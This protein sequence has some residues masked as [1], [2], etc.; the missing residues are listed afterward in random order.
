LSEQR[1]CPAGLKYNLGWK[2]R[3]IEGA[4][5]SAQGFGHSSGQWNA[6]FDNICNILKR[7][8][9]WQTD[10]GASLSLLY[11]ARADR[12]YWIYV[13]IIRLEK[14][15][16]MNCYPRF[17]VSTADQGYEYSI[18][19]F[20]AYATARFCRA[21]VDFSETEIAASKWKIAKENPFVAERSMRSCE[22]R[23][24]RERSAWTRE[25]VGEYFALNLVAI[26]A[27]SER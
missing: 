25:G 20:V 10:S 18:L 5:D 21:S 23:V 22:R 14:C 3:A 12:L 16:E 6:L 27:G 15:N 4:K 2:A 19:A 9:L 13:L 17:E 26:N 7:G 1:I 8:P 24:P 11:L